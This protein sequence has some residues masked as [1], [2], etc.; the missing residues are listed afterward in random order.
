MPNKPFSA[1]NKYFEQI[2]E[3]SNMKSRLGLD[4][5]TMEFIRSMQKNQFDLDS[6]AMKTVRAMN[7]AGLGLD[8]PAMKAIRAIN[9]VKL[10][11]D[12]QTMEAIR[13]INNSNLLDENIHSSSLLLKTALLDNMVSKLKRELNEKG[14]AL[15][16]AQSE[17][18]NKDE[19]IREFK[20]KFQEL[21]AQQDLAHIVNRVGE[22]GANKIMC[23]PEFLKNFQSNEPRKAYVLAIDIRRSTELMLKARTPQKFA[24]FITTLTML[25]RESVLENFG[26]FDKFTGDGILAVFPEFFSGD[27]AGFRV[28]NTAIRCHQIFEEIYNENR[29]CFVAVL[30]DAG[31]GIGIDYGD[32]HIVNIGGEFTVVGIPVVYACR[33]SGAPAYQTLLNQPAYEQLLDKYPVFDFAEDEI[34]VKHEGRTVVYKVSQNN[35]TYEPSLPSW[36][37][38][39]SLPQPENSAT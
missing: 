26:V 19:E 8:S 7:S 35:K 16:D 32:I 27:D 37:N 1:S 5:S 11:L 38:D 14:Q 18:E 2:Q 10:G 31:L 24:D 12:S 20:D 39:E 34:D 9:S 23:D 3:I 6:P 22:V 25:L 13:S 36:A 30:K 29:N 4:S 21:L 28:I 17:L 33:M 15:I